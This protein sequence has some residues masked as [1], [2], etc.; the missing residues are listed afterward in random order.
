MKKMFLLL[1]TATL[2]MTTGFIAE[3]M[4]SRQS[5]TLETSVTVY[6]SAH[7]TAGSSVYAIDTKSP[8]FYQPIRWNSGESAFSIQMS[9]VTCAANKSTGEQLY[10]SG[11]SVTFAWSVA[12]KLPSGLSTNTWFSNN[13]NLDLLEWNNIIS[14]TSVNV[15]SGNTNYVYSFPPDRARYVLLKATSGVTSVFTNLIVDMK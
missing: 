3:A 2:L 10:Q 1:W 14:G 12:N 5:N 8:S 15:Q 9:G 13:G 11:N 4:P 7:G 6:A